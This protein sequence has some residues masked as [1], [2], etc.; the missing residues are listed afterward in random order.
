MGPRFDRAAVVRGFTVSGHQND[1]SLGDDFPSEGERIASIASESGPDEQ[2]AEWAGG[3]SNRLLR[4][5]VNHRIMRTR[6]LLLAFGLASVAIPA[7]QAE[8]LDVRI[9]GNIR[10][11]VRPPPPPPAVVVVVADTG[12]RGPAEWEHNRWYKHTQ[13][14]YYYPGDDVYYRPTDQMW[15]FQERGQWRS[16]RH[17]PESIRIDFN[18]SITL[19][20]ATDRPYQFHQQVRTRYPSNY[21]GTRVRLRD[22]DRRDRDDNREHSQDRDRDNDKRHDNDEHDRP[23]SQDNRR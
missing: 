13:G 18:R 10:L 2:A 11:G 8:L 7:T 19:S 17:L 1:Q 12:P 3:P 16:G 20:M 4:A 23:K 5:G 15:F 9:I 6:F 21:F 22:D 14:Y